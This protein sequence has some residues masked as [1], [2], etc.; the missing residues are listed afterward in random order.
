VTSGLGGV[1]PTGIP[2]GTVIGQ[3]PEETGWE[4]IYV[5]RPASN[6]ESASHVLVLIQPS[7]SGVR[8][9]FQAQPDSGGAP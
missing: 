3:A 4:R 6:P 9:I 7:D 1:Y 8:G 2:V 5:L